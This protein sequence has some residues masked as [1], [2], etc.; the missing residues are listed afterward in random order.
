MEDEYFYTFIAKK[1]DN[2]ENNEEIV[3]NNTYNLRI[4]DTGPL[5]DLTHLKESVNFIYKIFTIYIIVV[6]LGRWFSFSI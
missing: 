3:S 4:K 6:F 1:N 5:D 2:I